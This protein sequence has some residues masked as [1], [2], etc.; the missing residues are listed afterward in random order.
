MKINGPIFLVGFWQPLKTDNSGNLYMATGTGNVLRTDEA[1]NSTAVKS[2]PFEVTAKAKTSIAISPGWNLISL[3]GA[4]VDGAGYDIVM[5]HNGLA[6]GLNVFAGYSSISQASD[7]GSSSIA[8]DKTQYA[9]GATYAVGSIT[10]GYQYSK[11]SRN[12]TNAATS[13]YENNAYGIS[14][15][16]NDDLSVSY[17]NHESEK[18]FVNPNNTETVYLEIESYQI[19]YTMGGVSMRYADTDV[20]NASYQTQA[21]YDNDARVFS[22]SL[23]F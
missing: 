6:D 17:G 18:G 21:G 8:G 12:G 23:A 10:V 3:P 1:G 13:F 14:F 4:P 19:A 7:A 20:T 11:D 22:V 16:V 5:T 2:H 15:N 9:L